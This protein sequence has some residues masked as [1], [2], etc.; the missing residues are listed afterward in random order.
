MRIWNGSSVDIQKDKITVK[1]GDVTDCQF[2]AVSV[3][4]S[5]KFGLTATYK[6]I[7]DKITFR[8]N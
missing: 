7:T 5:G 6:D 4:E 2:G 1:Y 8:T 3:S